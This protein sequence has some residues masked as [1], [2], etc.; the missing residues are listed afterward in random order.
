MVAVVVVQGSCGCLHGSYGCCTGQLR[1]LL[2]IRCCWGH[3]GGA[4]EKQRLSDVSLHW[5]VRR[6]FNL[7][8]TPSLF[9][10]FLCYRITTI[11]SSSSSAICLLSV[12]VGVV[13]TLRS[14]LTP[15]HIG[16]YCYITLFGLIRFIWI[17]LNNKSVLIIVINR[18]IYD[19]A[20]HNVE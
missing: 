6:L 4:Q 12:I 10:Y 1:L 13:F 7:Y 15:N 3:R 8:G 5:T 16:Y 9:V 18:P 20:F 2:V 11:S 17:L 14:V 19:S